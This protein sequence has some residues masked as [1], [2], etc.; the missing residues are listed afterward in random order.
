MYA[1]MY[2]F[3]YHSF[4]FAVEFSKLLQ[5]MTMKSIYACNIMVFITKKED[6]HTVLVI[7]KRLTSK[8]NNFLNLNCVSKNS[9]K[10]ELDNL[11]SLKITV[12]VYEDL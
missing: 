8:T 10:P 3:S 4:N 12:S 2:K 1:C 11:F 7:A 5:N 6:D 9:I